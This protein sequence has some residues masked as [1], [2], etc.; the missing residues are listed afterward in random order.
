MMHHVGIPGGRHF[1]CAALVV[2]IRATAV[3][4]NLPAGERTPER[5]FDTRAFALQAPLTFGSA[6]RN[7]V[8]GPGYA[9]VDF[10]LARTVAVGG[11]SQLELRWEVFTC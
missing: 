10:A 1:S 7:S 5:W 9:N 11:Q 6:P 8:V 4:A 3:A 2:M